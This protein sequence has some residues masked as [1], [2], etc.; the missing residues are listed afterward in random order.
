MLPRLIVCVLLVPALQA[1]GEVINWHLVHGDPA[2]V[3]VNTI[4]VDPVPAERSEASMRT[5]YV[6]VSRAV[7]RTSWE[8]V[9]Y[10]SFESTV[11][12]DCRRNTARYLAI[13]YYAEPVWR[14]AIA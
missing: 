10:R 11:L 9:P 6:R 5:L 13:A 3:A 14:G 4:L 8:G 12:F 1:Q 2:D 7:A